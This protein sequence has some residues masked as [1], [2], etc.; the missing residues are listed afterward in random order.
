MGVEIRCGVEVGKDVTIDQLRAQ[1]YKGFYLAIGCQGGRKPGVPGEDAAG[2]YTAV[3]FLKEAGQKEGFDLGGDVVVVGGGNVAID[4]A[5]VS[6]RCGTGKV[7]MFCLE[8]RDEMP[9]SREEILEATE[10]KV[11]IRNG[12]GPQEILTENGRAVGVVFKKCI[13]VFD[14]NHRFAPV[15]DEQETMTVACSDRKSVV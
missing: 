15:Y 5:R 8:S 4:A 9:A 13:R 6:T 3:E 1:G 12:W 11:A 2:V 14:D 7:S 10:E